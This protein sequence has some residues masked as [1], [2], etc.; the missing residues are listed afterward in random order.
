MVARQLLHFVQAF[1]Y[2]ILLCCN[3]QN[4][5]LEILNNISG[6]TNG[7]DKKNPNDRLTLVMAWMKLRR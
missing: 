5:I 6:S 4:S 3:V 1:N 2:L 7:C